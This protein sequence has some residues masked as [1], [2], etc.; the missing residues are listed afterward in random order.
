MINCSQIT[1][2]DTAAG[3]ATTT[4]NT[5]HA[6]T[7]ITVITT[8]VSLPGEDAMPTSSSR[9]SPDGGAIAGSVVAAILFMGLLAVAIVIMWQYRK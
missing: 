4:A 6:S 9:K 3:V 8:M 2:T 7:R 5:D 1:G